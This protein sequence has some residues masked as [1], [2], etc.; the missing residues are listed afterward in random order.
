MSLIQYLKDKRYFLLFYIISMLF[1][2]LILIV[3]VNKQHA[4]NNLIYVHITCLFFALFYLIIGYYYRNSF[5]RKL[6]ESIR[7]EQE[8]ITTSLPLPQNYEQALYLKLLQR[9]HVEHS[10]QLQKLNNEMRE[11]QDFILSWIHEVKLPI[12]SSRLLME[13]STGK[14][15]EVIVD[16]L[17]DE[18]NKIDH[19]IEQALYYSR[20]DSF[21]KDYF[22]TEVLIDQIIKESVKKHAKLFIH[23]RILF[24]MYEIPQFIQSD[25]KWLGFIIDQILSNSLKYTNQGGSITISFE[26]D[27]LEKRLLLQDS[28]IGIKSEDI[29]RVFEKGFT[30]S[31]GR[32][33]IKSTGMG[34]YLAQ[35]LA[36]KLGHH[37]SIQSKEGYYTKLYIHFPKIRS[38]QLM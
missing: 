26:E 22:I 36:V 18:L 27:D 16:K 29:Q 7:N 13:Q 35:K 33:H 14:T 1:I 2:S 4:I 25:S 30:G 24:T 20:I 3:S 19:Y 32:S 28:G 6:S 5:F 8:E 23:K 9:V 31:T 11:H 37:L 21:S 10:V 15:V 34:L 38:F 17:E 12:A